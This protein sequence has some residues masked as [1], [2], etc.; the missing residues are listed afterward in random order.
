MINIKTAKEMDGMREA[1]RVACT[2]KER[3]AKYI[4]PGMT[5]KEIDMY[6]KK[7]IEEMG[8]VSAFLGYRGYP[9]YTCISVNDEVVHGI[10]GERVIQ[11]GDIVSLDVGVEYGGFIGDNATTQ[12]VG[13]TDPEVINLV[14]VSWQSLE[15]AIAQAVPGNRLSDI[16]HAVE[17]V[18]VEAGYSVVRDFVGHGIGR[19]MHEEPQIPNFGPPGRGPKLKEGMTFAIEP[20]VNM[21]SPKVEVLSDGWTVLTADRKPSVHVEH[22]VAIREGGGEIL[23]VSGDG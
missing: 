14:K 2:I 7:L 20:M 6:A 5:T 18:V 21:G 9:G 16:S 8:A 22:T 10:P 19:T 3:T 11:M 1:G 4:A 13:V 12:M 23:T 15:A 17:K